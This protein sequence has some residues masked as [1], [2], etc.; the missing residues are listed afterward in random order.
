MRFGLIHYT[1][2]WRVEGEITLD[3]PPSAGNLVWCNDGSSDDFDDKIY[4]VDH[5]M[6]GEQCAYL[7]VRPYADYGEKRPAPDQNVVALLRAIKGLDDKVAELNE[8]IT[9]LHDDVVAIEGTLGQL[10][11]R[12][13][14]LNETVDS[15]GTQLAE[16]H[17][18]HYK[19]TNGLCNDVAEATAAINEQH[20]SIEK[21][22]DLLNLLR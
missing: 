12:A 20:E 9:A 21:I 8:R 16:Q 17:D 15:L 22:V 2:D 7:L 14:T 11:E 4:Y 10:H 18:E 1:D 19:L 13:E 6:F 3:T 5:V